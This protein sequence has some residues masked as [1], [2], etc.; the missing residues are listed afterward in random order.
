MQK[1]L[2]VDDEPELVRLIGQTLDAAGF[3][4]VGAASG[5]R[6]LELANQQEFD[7]AL[8]DKNLGRGIDGVEVL[9][10]LRKRQPRCACIIMTA[11]PSM[12]SAVEALRI[13]AQDYVE[14]PSPELDTIADRVQAAIRAV[15]LR[16]ERDGILRKLATLEEQLRIKEQ[17][18]RDQKVDLAIADEVVALRVDE[19]RESWRVSSRQRDARLIASAEGLLSLARVLGGNDKLVSAIEAHLEAL[20]Q[21]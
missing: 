9:R 11:Y 18:I 19:S 13:G 21:R 12:G 5:E 15:Q 6:A 10:H 16:D 7:A 8:V 20:R 1:V 2:V 17:Q 4:A 3:A 14:K